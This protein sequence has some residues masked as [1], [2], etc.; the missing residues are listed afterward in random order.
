MYSNDVYVLYE[1]GYGS[2]SKRELQALT[3]KVPFILRADWSVTVIWF[4]ADVGALSGAGVGEAITVKPEVP[5]L[6]IRANPP[7]PEEDSPLFKVACY[8]PDAI[9]NLVS[10]RH[11]TVL[12]AIHDDQIAVCV[13]QKSGNLGRVQPGLY[14]L[15]GSL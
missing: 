8:A 11:G 3:Q 13:D 7:V 15:M 6:L 1:H 2:F 5:K 9:N 10:F 4:S 12:Y 14:R